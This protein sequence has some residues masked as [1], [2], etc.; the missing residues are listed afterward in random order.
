MIY[1]KN[2]PTK[3]KKEKKTVKTRQADREKKLIKTTNRIEKY[4]VQSH[5]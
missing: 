1:R 4:C 2:D 5:L 3:R